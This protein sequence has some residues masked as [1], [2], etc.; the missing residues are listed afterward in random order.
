[1]NRTSRLP[2]LALLL[3]SMMCG[4]ALTKANLDLSYQPEQGAK[5]PLSTIPHMTV[6]LQV[7]DKRPV[8]E[9]N[10]VGNKKN[11]YGMT[12]AAILPNREPTLVLYDALKAELTN[13]GHTVIDTPEPST[14][15]LLVVTLQRYWIDTLIHFAD[16]EVIGTLNTELLL[17]NPRIDSVLLTQP[18]NSTQRESRQIVTDSAF[19]SVLNRVL[20]EYIRSFSRDPNI[21]EAL[22]KASQTP[23]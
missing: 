18:H 21:L 1:M 8:E 11:M 3:L 16:V 20:V 7:E 15:V 9:R 17:R 14:N 2:L 10:R 5:S 23:N 12:M 6:Q 22:K 4:C 19:Q 13:N